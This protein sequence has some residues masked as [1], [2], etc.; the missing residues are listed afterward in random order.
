MES[1][2]VCSDI[3]LEELGSTDMTIPSLDQDKK[4]LVDK[5]PKDKM[6]THFINF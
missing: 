6:A 5:L 2:L 4:D 1:Y 3:I